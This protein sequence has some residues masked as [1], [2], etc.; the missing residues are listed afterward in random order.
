MSKSEKI[1]A[2]AIFIFVSFCT[3]VFAYKYTGGNGNGGGGGQTNTGNNVE[4]NTRAAACAPATAL[5]DLAWNNVEAL[6][7]TGGSMWQD[8]ANSTSAYEIPKVEDANGPCSLYAGALWMGGI[9]PD[10]QLKLAA[11]TFRQNGNDFW[12]GPLT[13][14]GTAE[15]TENVCEYY[16]QFFVSYRLDAQRHYQYQ[17]A[18]LNNTVEEEFPDGYST[19]SYFQDYPAIGNTAIGQDYFLAPFYDYNQNLVYDPEYGDFPWYDFLREINCKERRRDDPIPLFGDQTFFWIFNDKG[20]VHSESQ[21][22]P[23]GMEVRAQAFAFN[24]TDEVNNMTFY[25]YVL[26]NQGTQTLTKT[27]FGVWVDADLGFSGDDYVGCDVQRGLGYCYNG[28][29]DDA[30]A[31]GQLGYGEN[32]P[33]VGVDFFEGPYQDAD[34]IDNPLTIDFQDANDSLGIPYRGIGIGYGDGVEDNERFGM[35]RF[36]YYNNNTNP[37]NGEPDT[38]LH[39]YNYMNG[40]WKNGQK[41]LYGGNGVEGQSGVTAIECDYMF[42]DDT[43]PYN[44]GTGGE[45]VDTWSEVSSGNAAFDRRFIQAAGPFTLEPGDYNNITLGVV[46]ARS[47]SGDPFESVNLL[48][49]ADDKAQSLFDNCFE[50]VS[51]PDA[52]DVDVVELDKEIILILANENG[53][54]NNYHEEYVEFDPSIPEQLEDGTQ[55]DSLQRS[56][57]FQGYLVYQLVNDQ[58]GPNELDDVTKARLV[59][60]SDVRDGISDI[61]N[62]VK[63]FETNL[64][65]PV[66]R[67]QGADE[68]LQHSFR[69]FNDEFAQGDNRLVNHKTYYFMVIG[70]GFNQYQIYNTESQSGQAN[71]FISSRKA[72]IG[73]IQTL[74]AIPHKVDPASGGTLLNSAYGD[75]VMITRH[76]G[77]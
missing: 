6:I 45:S 66:L 10:K 37:V 54:S 47:N 20:N 41:M 46:W 53:I 73:E 15:V 33:A 18:T 68:G 7:E 74:T 9:S 30:T 44:W 72:A 3:Q 51:G 38:P 61:V 55:I 60:Q 12:T 71:T 28:D 64:V 26:I 48:R 39:Y 52:P 42:P 62:Y 4:Q 32:P 59:A 27:Y 24:T 22:Q 75:G 29:A 13:N 43:D 25:N 36:V 8:R 49:V 50:L 57:Q 63:D 2:L 40:I 76:E 67:V 58:V 65:T 70:Y 21:G 14:D 34:D 11:I 23:I 77:K 16:D 5:M 31:D 69:I 1:K 19:P 56:Y 17:I 35:R